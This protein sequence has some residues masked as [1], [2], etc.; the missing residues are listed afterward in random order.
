MRKKDEEVTSSNVAQKYPA[1]EFNDTTDFD[2]T[3][4]PPMTLPGEENDG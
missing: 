3:K 2:M 4:I 1:P